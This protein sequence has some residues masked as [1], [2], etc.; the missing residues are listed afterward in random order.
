[1]SEKN[2]NANSNTE[3]QN[4]PQNRARTYLRQM[5]NNTLNANAIL[6]ITLTISV[7]V[8]IVVIGQFFGVNSLAAYGFIV[9]IIMLKTA[10]FSA[11]TAG[12]HAICSSC[13]GHADIKGA[14][15]CFNASLIVM[16]IIGIVFG[17]LIAIFAVPLIQILDVGNQNAEVIDSAKFLIFGLAIGFPFEAYNLSVSQLLLV[18]NDRER[19]NQSAV[20]F[21]IVSIVG[22]FVNVF[23]LN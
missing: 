17:G 16:I 2:L 10:I 23:V 19:T 1:M 4:Q 21:A 8:D 3:V 12:E 6:A 22:D 15:G 13:I 20:L 11:I 14:N 5:F 7:V 18:D 9:P